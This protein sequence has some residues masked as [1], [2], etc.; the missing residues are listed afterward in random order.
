MPPIANLECLLNAITPGGVRR[1]RFWRRQTERRLLAAMIGERITVPTSDRTLDLFTLG[2]TMIRFTPKGYSRL[3]E[4]GE[5]EMRS[6]G[7]ESNVAVGLA[8]LGLTTAWAS[9]LPEGPLGEFVLRRIRGFGVDVSQVRRTSRGRMGLYFIEPGAAPRSGSV[10]YDRADSAASTMSP[11]EFDWTVLDRCRHVH[12]T[13]ITPA[14]SDS[15][16]AT[17]IVA[18]TEARA[19]GCTTSFDVNYRARLW[20]PG[21]ARERLQPLMAG[22]DLIICPVIDA[23]VVFGIDGTPEEQA[24]ALAEATGARMVAMTLTAGGAVLW[25]GTALTREEPLPVLAV[26]RVGAGDAFDVGLLWG[27]LR[28]EAPR[29][30]R[31]GVALAAL[32]HT[33][34]GDELVS[35]LE[36]VESLLERGHRDIQR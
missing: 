25:D 7:S 1:F 16:S 29:G 24:M 35:S 10:L 30:L 19:R 21:A 23:R 31:Y 4:A 26:D 18:M 22:V 34:P 9:K 12:L 2:E 17:A 8:R 20:S 3:E 13:G 5:V 33:I 36:E 14:L 6:G 28:G 27:F 15:A 11:D 32:K